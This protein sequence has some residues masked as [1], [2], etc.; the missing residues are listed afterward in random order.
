M[1]PGRTRCHW[2][3]PVIGSEARRRVL[4]PVS[5]VPSTDWVNTRPFATIASAGTTPLSLPPPTGSPLV[6]LGWRRLTFAL[7]S[8]ASTWFHRRCA[9]VAPACGQSPAAA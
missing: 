3:W 4:K 2:N 8:V 5:N 6:H 7:L 1:T 9:A